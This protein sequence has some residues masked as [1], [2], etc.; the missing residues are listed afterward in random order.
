MWNAGIIQTECT[1][2]VSGDSSYVVNWLDEMNRENAICNG[3]ISERKHL[4]ID[5]RLKE[6]FLF[7][8]NAL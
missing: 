5:S 3:V 6:Q 8:C 1:K 7:H 4:E 2:N